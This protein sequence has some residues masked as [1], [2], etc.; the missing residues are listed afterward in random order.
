LNVQQS[1][2]LGVIQGLTEFIPVSSTAHLILAPQVFNVPAPRPE[3]AH[4]YDTFIQIGTVIPVLIY[5]WHEW[6]KLLK[7]GVQIVKQGRVGEDPEQRILKY[8]LVG[9]LPAGVVG[10]LLEKRI[11]R[12]ANP[13]E[14]PPA[15][16]I[17]GTS[18]IVVGVIMWWAELTGRKTRTIENVRTVDAWVVGCAQAL[19]LIPGVSRSGAT[20]T[21]G[22]FSGLTR[23]A[24]ARFSFLLM[25]PIMLAATGYKLLKLLKG[26]EVMSAGEWQGMLLATVVAAITGYAAI[27]FLLGWLRNRS[28]GVFA[29][30]RILVG[31]FSIGLFFMQQPTHP[32]SATGTATA[33][34]AARVAHAQ[35]ADAALPRA[36]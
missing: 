18:L 27:A 4:T 6:L 25:T 29:I 21:A 30:Y 10:L 36:R 9:S 7:A 11:E 2:V 1:L 34:P 35:P 31:A 13:A 17:I 20:I 22:L 28:L 15:F 23:E 3:V 8:L 26:G 14:F 16:L 24:A 32:G 19:A 5:F 12:F 33:R